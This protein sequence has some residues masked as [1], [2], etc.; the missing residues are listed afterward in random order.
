MTAAELGAVHSP[1]TP[2]D[3]VSEE[4]SERVL[5]V[6]PD[7]LVVRT[8]D[9][10]VVVWNASAEQ[11]FGWPAPDVLGHRLI[12]LHMEQLEAIAAE[13][14]ASGAPVDR[15]LLVRCRD[16]H[17]VAT[18]LRASLLHAQQ[19]R[20]GT[21]VL[22]LSDLTDRLAA[23]QELRA[24]QRQIE[25]LLQH[26]ADMVALIDP[27]GTI[28]FVNDAIVKRAQYQ[29]GDLVGRNAFGFVHPDDEAR[30]RDALADLIASGGFSSPLRL[31]IRTRRGGDIWLEGRAVN[32]LQQPSVGA[33]LIALHDVTNRVVTESRLA[34]Q[35][36]HD[37][38]TDLPN[39]ALFLDRL[40]HHVQ[41]ALRHG[42][43]VSLFFWDVDGFKN[44]NDRAG[45][46]VGDGLLT[47]VAS[48]AQQALRAED[49]IARMGGDEFVAC[50]EVES[51]AQ[52]CA[53]AER[54]LEALRISI[55]L[56]AG[57]VMQATASIG[58]AF[59][60]GTSA[61]QLLVEADRAMYDA[62]RSGGAAIVVLGVGPD[63]DG[64]A[65]EARKVD[66]DKKD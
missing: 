40:E 43:I 21:V 47:E 20:P 22:V 5:G 6:I 38:L 59:G 1:G 56:P 11:L 61:G 29:E 25:M 48:R 37:A 51:E 14:A 7:V 34:Y 57:E 10:E 50:A 9:G 30:V 15:E 39:R 36:T 41:H 32:L 24:S 54:L 49:S 17:F 28:K 19:A 62:K 45:H 2:M 26:S 3:L 18:S 33:V 66:L 16:G 58:V 27:S 23:E 13:V 35:A 65:T 52:V 63:T 44:V 12:D 8:G 64:S 60:R 53:L 4:F 55:T 42:Q 31:R 46:A